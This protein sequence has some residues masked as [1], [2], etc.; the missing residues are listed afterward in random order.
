M[1]VGLPVE[2]RLTP[3]RVA[4]PSLQ[5]TEGF[6][7]ALSLSEFASE[8]CTAGCVV[9]DLGVAAG[10]TPHP[11]ARVHRRCSRSRSTPP[12]RPRG[13]VACRPQNDNAL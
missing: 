9:S 11:A 3:D 10:H 12:R 6:P 8:I 13:S 7:A 5:T 1:L 2:L 4:D